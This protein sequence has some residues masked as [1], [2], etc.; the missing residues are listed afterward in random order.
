MTGFYVFLAIAGLICVIISFLLTEK[1]DGKKAFDA[2]NIP[3]EVIAAII[4]KN[5][6]TVQKALAS[7]VEDAKDRTVEETTSILNRLA[8]EKIMAV[9]EF[10]DTVIEKINQNHSEVI[11]LYNMLNE[12]EKELKELVASV[13]Q[14]SK[15]KVVAKEKKE[16]EIVNSQNA[17]P[18][19][20]YQKKSTSQQEKG[21]KS[22]SEKK[23]KLVLNA[24]EK[25]KEAHSREEILAMYENG[26]SVTDIAQNLKM[27][28]GEVK[29]IIDLYQGAKG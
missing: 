1:L 7:Q 3:D 4:E 10:S 24:E 22:K 12:K 13:N 19:K 15:Q 8:N 17:S 21:N 16:N 23:D 25:K 9:D 11:F 5:S 14:A 2:S 18:A 20:A 29:L 27:G 28:K 26:M 6:Y